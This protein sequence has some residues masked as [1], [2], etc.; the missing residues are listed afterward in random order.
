M[1]YLELAQNCVC[2]WK[3]PSIAKDYPG[4]VF[5]S[6]PVRNYVVGRK[7][8]SATQIAIAKTFY[9]S[10]EQFYSGV[11]NNEVY[12]ATSEE[13][14]VCSRT[15]AFTQ[16]PVFAYAP[17]SCAVWTPYI[18]DSAP[19][20]D[21]VA[22]G[23]SRTN[24]TAY[25]ARGYGGG[26]SQYLTGTL[27]LTGTNANKVISVSTEKALSWPQYLVKTNN[28]TCQ[29]LPATKGI[30]HPGAVTIPDPNFHFWVGRKTFANGQIAL[31]KLE[32]NT[33]KQWYTNQNGV[34]VGEQA[35]EVLVCENVDPLPPACGEFCDFF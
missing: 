1:E 22:A 29:W 6:D 11:N 13:V 21:G 2:E 32:R 17:G 26:Q 34:E 19:T 7:S 14:L 10:F 8:I 5:T 35:T 33:M 24:D 23:L 27:Q 12:Q 9:P 18:G 25:V 28:C 4:L 15:A 16:P 3:A 20:I 31:S 30:K